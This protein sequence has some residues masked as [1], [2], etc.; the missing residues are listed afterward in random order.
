MFKY[1]NEKA[2]DYESLYND[3]LNHFSDIWQS[4]APSRFG[5]FRGFVFQERD[6]DFFLMSLLLTKVYSTA[7]ASSLR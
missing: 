1:L 3:N 6:S 7:A 5:L 4:L 2:C